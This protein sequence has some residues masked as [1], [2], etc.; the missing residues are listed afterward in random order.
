MAEA[1]VEEVGKLPLLPVAE[2][3]DLLTQA[4][5]D[6]IDIRRS[7]PL[8]EQRWLR[9]YAPDDVPGHVAATIL[10]RCTA[11]DSTAYEYEAYLDAQAGLDRI[12]AHKRPLPKDLRPA[13][14]KLDNAAPQAAAYLAMHGAI[15][16]TA[17][18]YVRDYD[19]L[20]GVDRDR[21]A[22]EIYD[23]TDSV[24]HPALEDISKYRK[25]VLGDQAIRAERIIRLLM[26]ERDVP[27]T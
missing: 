8:E 4:L 13:Q 3:P 12:L 19:G 21:I 6:P 15:R 14:R 23:P 10:L 17:A 11:E 26:I 1:A 27:P 2:Q 22:T 24:R 20:T 25:Q 18:K 9:R 7:I 16:G 5:F